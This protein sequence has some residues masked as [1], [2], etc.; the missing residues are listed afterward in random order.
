[1]IRR[2]RAGFFRTSTP[3][4][5]ALP[6]SGQRGEDLDSGGF[7]RAVWPKK[8]KHGA[9]RH[10]DVQPV[11]RADILVGFHEATCLDR[12]HDDYSS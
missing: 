3:S 12:V 2:S 6:A 9:A 10:L 11:E 8:T 1:M 5:V 4:T 7:A